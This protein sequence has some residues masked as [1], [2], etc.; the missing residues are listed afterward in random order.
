MKPQSTQK[1]FAFIITVVMFFI[2]PELVSAQKTELANAEKKCKGCPRGYVC[3]RGHC[4]LWYPIW[5][6]FATTDET[7]SASGS[8]VNAINF[9]IKQPEFISIKLL[10]VGGRLIKTLVNRRMTQGEHQIE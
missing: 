3:Y 7:L 8:L 9:Q 6:V 5:S 2:L 1:F 10:D 4:V